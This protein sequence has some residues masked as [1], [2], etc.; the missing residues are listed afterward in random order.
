MKYIVN[1]SNDPAY[2]VALEAYAFQKLTDIDEIFILWINE[3]AIIIGRHQNTIQEINKEF[4]DKNG[5]HVVRRLSGGGAVYHD[6]NNLN[7]TIISNNTQE[8]AFDFQTFS[9]PVIDTLAKLG[10]KAEFTGR[11]DLEINGQKFAGNAQAYYKGRMMHHGCLLFDVDM[12]VL[13]QALKVSKD[14]IESK[15]IKSVRARVTNIVD[16]LSD[17]ITVQEFSD[18]ILAQMKEEYPEMD[19]Y[20]L[21]DAELSEIQAMRDNQF[22]TWDWTYGKAPEYTIERGVRYPAGKIT[23]YAN[24][25]NSTIKSVK[26]FGD[27]FGVKPVDDIEKM[28]EGVRYDY[29]DVLAALKTVDT[30][31]YFSRMTPEEITKAIVD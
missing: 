31:Q 27:F 29:K 30:S 26:I 3:P 23:T 2:N 14:K 19:E 28:L 15:G 11:N 18:A 24:V 22:A 5:I 4:I 20:V 9:K 25:E 7:Y 21:S 6:L 8:G 16:H 13:G 12:S 10:V 17:K 1:T